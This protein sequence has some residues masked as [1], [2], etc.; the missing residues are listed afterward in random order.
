[1]ID[2]L[3]S[4]SWWN[5]MEAIGYDGG[6][7]GGGYVPD[8]GIPT[9]SVTGTDYLPPDINDYSSWG[10]PDLFDW[11]QYAPSY[12]GAYTWDPLTDYSGGPGCNCGG[13]VPYVGSGSGSGS[14][15][16]PSSGGSGGSGGG[17]PTQRPPQQQKPGA[18]PWLLLALIAIVVY[19]AKNK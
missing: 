11:G 4:S 15:R 14:P 17:T 6:G 1:M 7:G 18:N 3:W 9:F 5:G 19:A 10:T 16:P 13:N 12:G 8:G 2:D